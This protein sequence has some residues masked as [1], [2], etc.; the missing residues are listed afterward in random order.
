ML[1]SLTVSFA[2]LPHQ[3]TDNSLCLSTSTSCATFGHARRA[4]YTASKFAVKGLTESLSLEFERFGV[5]T[6]DIL[7]PMH[8]HADVAS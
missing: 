6:A 7:K 5:R 1:S 8:R 3:V 4:A 2:A